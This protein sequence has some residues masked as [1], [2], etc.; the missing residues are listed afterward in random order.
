VTFT[1][2]GVITERNGRDS[3]MHLW[4]STWNPAFG[5]RSA[6]FADY[7]TVPGISTGSHRISIYISEGTFFIFN[8]F[9]RVGKHKETLSFAFTVIGGEIAW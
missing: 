8:L 9:V 5:D 3:A 1:F 6:P 7:G 2:K 4:I